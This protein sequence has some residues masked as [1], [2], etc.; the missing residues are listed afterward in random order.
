MCIFWKGMIVYVIG[1]RLFFLCVFFQLVILEG[2]VHFRVLVQKLFFYYSFCAF[3]VVI[4]CL[5]FVM[6]VKKSPIFLSFSLKINVSNKNK[7]IIIII[8]YYF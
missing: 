5:F 1:R 2:W 7:F 8:N 6:F 4:R 3:K